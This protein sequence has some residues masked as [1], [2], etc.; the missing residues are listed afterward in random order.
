VTA[1]D[2]L[3]TFS[4]VTT[5]A[6]R[7]RDE[8]TGNFVAD[9]ISAVLFPAANREARIKGVPNRNGIFVFSGL[10]GL[11]DVERGEGDSG[12]WQSE[13]ARF[14][15]VLEVRDLLGRYQPFT[16][17]V[18]L[19]Q[20]R[21]L[22]LALVSPPSSPLAMQGGSETGLLPLFST[23]A[24]VAPD[25]MTG[26]RMELADLVDPSDLASAVPAA[27]AVVEAKAGEQRLAVGLADAQ[28]RIFVP[29]LYPKPVIT[30]GSPGNGGA[31]TPLTEQSWAVDFTV[32][33]RRRSPVPEIPDLIDVLTQPPATAWVETALATPWS[34]ATLR[35]G[36]ELVL[37]TRD[38]GG[39]ATSTV[40][41][42]PAG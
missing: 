27:W 9:R 20:R 32:R 36:R 14:D 3:E 2:V 34:S 6:V 7:L 18:K 37:A 5:L 23:A 22:D 25:G 39:A 15:F 26:L 10:P 30:L 8:A 4:L 24:R 13:S 41:I 21:V 28:G 40:L 19:P 31:N 33:Y 1:V 11:R 35:F 16:L 29:L 42:T 38:G 12:Y 17:P